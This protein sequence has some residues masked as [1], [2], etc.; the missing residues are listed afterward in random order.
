VTREDKRNTAGICTG[1]KAEGLDP[2]RSG[3]S[4]SG[5]IQRRR[6][7][8]EL[9]RREAEQ[10]REKLQGLESILKKFGVKKA[11]LFGS[12][13]RKFCSADSDIDLY[14]EDLTGEMYWELWRMLEEATGHSIDL[15]CQ[16]DDSVFV[17]KIKERGEVIYEG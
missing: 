14:V 15:Y 1:R 5:F 13:V 6:K 2:G 7:L 12:T 16:S 8:A 10:R 17:K 4:F 9:G 3:F 11:Y